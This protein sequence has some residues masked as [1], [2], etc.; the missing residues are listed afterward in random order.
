MGELSYLQ[1]SSSTGGAHWD[2]VFDETKVFESDYEVPS[3]S[4]TVILYNDFSF[5]KIILALFPAL[6]TVE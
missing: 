2:L 5:E 4:N 3:S 1:K 6:S